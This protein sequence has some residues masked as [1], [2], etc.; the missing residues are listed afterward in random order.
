VFQLS[1]L[2]YV[3]GMVWRLQV[4]IWRRSFDTP[5]PPMEPDNE[6]YKVIQEDERYADV[7]KDELPTCESLELTIKR[8]LPFW[9][10]VVVPALKAEKKVRDSSCERHCFFPSLFFFLS[11]RGSFCHRTLNNTARARR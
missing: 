11:G 10:D 6:F 4:K 8:T 2:A 1:S 5:P 9:N 7:P 3:G